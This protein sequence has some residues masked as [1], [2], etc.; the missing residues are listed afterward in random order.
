MAF[1][2]ICASL[3]MSV[4]NITNIEFFFACPTSLIFFAGSS[5]LKKVIP[6]NSAKAR[7]FEIIFEGKRE[8]I[9]SGAISQQHFGV[10]KKITH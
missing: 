3:M 9:K 2:E 7:S 6:A 8:K 5:I 4:G 10:D 1:S